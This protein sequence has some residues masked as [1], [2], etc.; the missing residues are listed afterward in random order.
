M[1]TVACILANAEIVAFVIP[2]YFLSDNGTQFVRNFF[3]TMCTN[4]RTEHMKKTAYHSQTNGQ[5]E[6]CNK[7]IL[8]RLLDY[9]A[10]R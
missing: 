5:V 2:S 4:L 9:T 6:R 10:T 7:T 3:G 8:N 1:T